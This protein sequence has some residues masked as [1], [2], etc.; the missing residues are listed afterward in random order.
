MQN[1]LGNPY[2]DNYILKESGKANEDSNCLTPGLLLSPHPTPTQHME[3]ILLFYIKP[4]WKEQCSQPMKL[5]NQIVP[6][7]L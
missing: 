5:R 6:S 2:L 1:D 4:L 7:F 3:I